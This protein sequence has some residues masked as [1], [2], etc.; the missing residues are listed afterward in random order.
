M[1]LSS[2]QDFLEWDQIKLTW[3]YILWNVLSLPFSF[4][5]SE[6]I[7]RKSQFDA[8]LSLTSNTY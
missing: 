7:K 3:H 4:R 8:D 1:T 2:T 6:C 5:P